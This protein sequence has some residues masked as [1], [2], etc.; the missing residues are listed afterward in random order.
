[1]ETAAAAR[2]EI[3]WIRDAAVEASERIGDTASHIGE[4]QDRFTAALR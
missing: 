3:A 2:P 1:M 4:Q